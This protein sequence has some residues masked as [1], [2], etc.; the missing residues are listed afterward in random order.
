M[1]LVIVESPTK[2]KTIS[3]FLSDGFVVK[4]SMGHVMDLPK[5]TLGIDLEHEF[6]PQYEMVADRAAIVSELKKLSKTADGVILATDPDREGEAI[7]AHIQEVLAQKSKTKDQKFSR[8]AFHEITKDAIEDALQNPRTIDTAL[9]DAQTARRV[10]DRLVGY[11]LSPILWQKVRRGLSAGRVQSVALR[12]IVEREK[13]IQKFVKENYWTIAVILKKET[14]SSAKATADKGGTEFELIEISGEKI[15]LSQ[16]FKLY[17]G[18][19]KV[20]KTT[21]AAQKEADEIVADLQTKHFVV[22]DVSKKQTKRSP[23]PP[24]TTSTLQQDGARRLGF[25]GKRTMSL[26]QKLY[27]EGFI[28]YHRTDSVNLAISAVE[29]MRAYVKKEFGEQ[30]IPQTPRFFSGKQKNAQ[31]AHEAIRPTEV[32]R[33]IDVVTE[34]LGSQ[35]GKLY[36]LIWRRA[37]ASQMSDALIESTVVLVDS[38]PEKYRLKTNGSILV[39]EGFL[40]VNPFGLQDRQLPD[41]ATQETLDLVSVQQTAHETPPPPRYNDASLVASLEDEGIGRPSTYASII[42]TIESRQYIERE[43]GRFT[44]THVGVAVNDFLVEHFANID[45]IPFTAKIEDELDNIAKGE[46]EWVPMMKDF[47]TPFEKQLETVKSAGRVKIEVE[48]LDEQCPKDGGTL[49]VRTGRFGKFISCKNFPTCDFKKAFVQ[50]VN[51]PC[52]KD[53][54]RVVIKRTKKGRTFYGCANYPNCDF[55]VWKLQDIGKEGKSG[56]RSAAA[57]AIA[58]KKGESEKVK[59]NAVK[60]ETKTVKQPTKKRALKKSAK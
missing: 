60:V 42:G 44:P 50:D 7:A 20:S 2:A 1:K 27:E 43:Q 39:F 21:I 40:K 17:N 51:I 26:A 23:Q 13:E 52:P 8:I 16:T 47:Y 35:Y 32:S 31:E 59:R 3:K 29:K 5:S 53:G 55:A 37:V 9:V 58:D 10:L 46:R 4:A 57:K 19:Y 28:T 22:A 33:S 24:F 45:D 34:K 38:Q 15:E 49:V 36:E 18:D 56:K 12:L 41:F 48:E 6:A 11:K 25:S 30:Y 54:G 14:S